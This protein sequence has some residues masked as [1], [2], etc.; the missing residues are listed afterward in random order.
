MRQLKIR[1]FLDYKKEERWLNYLAL[2][3]KALIKCKPL[4]YWFE[5][6]APSEYVYR[7]EL[8]ENMPNQNLG[9]NYI[10]FL[11]EFKIECIGSIYGWG[12]LRKKTS[13]GELELLSDLDSKLLYSKR[14]GKNY[15]VGTIYLLLLTFGLFQLFYSNMLFSRILCGLL[16]FIGIYIG[17]LWF[18]NVKEAKRIKNEMISNE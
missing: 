16:I 14:L 8:F 11:N 17:V 3:G 9:T 7:I 10:H 18:R 2:K 12:Y 5:N 4:L 6:T 13:D 15:L 1:F